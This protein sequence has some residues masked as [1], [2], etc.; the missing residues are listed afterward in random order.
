MGSSDEVLN[1]MLLSYYQIEYNE[2]MT[3][4]KLSDIAMQYAIRRDYDNMKICFT[5]AIDKNYTPAMIQLGKYYEKIEINVDEMIRLYELAL[6]YNNEIGVIALVDYYKLNNDIPNVLKYLNIYVDKYND[7]QSMH[8]LIIYYHSINDEENSM[9]YCNKL[10]AI[11]Q[12]QGH[13]YK[14]KTYEVVKKYSE[15]KS[16]YDYFLNNVNITIINNSSMIE[17]QVSHILKLYLDN[18]IN[19]PFVQEILH[20]INFTHAHILGHV[21]YKLNKIKLKDPVYSKIGSCNICMN[22]DIQLQLF[23]CLG[24]YYCLDCTINIDKCALCKCTKKCS[25][26]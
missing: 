20:K 11:D 25:H 16:H 4:E 13:F 12:L 26:S 21:Q 17:K 23:D 3:G 19:I 24:H 18:D 22:D 15:M 5:M 8:D 2:S 10:F 14:G 9:K 1:I 6:H 7:K